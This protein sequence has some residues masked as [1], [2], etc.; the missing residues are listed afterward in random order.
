MKAPSTFVGWKILEMTNEDA[1]MNPFVGL[2]E[3]KMLFHTMHGILKEE[4][5]VIKHFRLFH[6]SG[7]T[8]WALWTK[9]SG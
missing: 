6:S 9:V 3:V 8:A 7:I 5:K 4:R 2:F 1:L